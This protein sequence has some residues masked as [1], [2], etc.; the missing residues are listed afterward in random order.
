MNMK[1]LLLGLL[2]LTF[3]FVIVACDDNDDPTDPTEVAPPTQTETDGGTDEVGL[4]SRA[5]ELMAEWGLPAPRFTPD[6]NIPS[7]QQDYDHFV[8]LV[9]YVNYGWWPAHEMGDSFVTQVMRDDMNIHISFISGGMDNL[10]TMIAGG[11]MPDIITMGGY[12]PLVHQAYEFAFPLN[13][14]AELYDPY[15]LA[16]VAHPQIVN[17]HTLADGHFY[18]MPN[19]AMTADAI[20]AGYAWTNAGFLVRQD[21][22]EELGDV[23]M[24][25]PEGFLAALRGARDLVPYADHGVPLVAFA[26]HA[27]DIME[28]EDGAFGSTLQDFLAIPVV[29]A[30]GNWYDRDADPEYLE[31][32][33]V[34]RQAME[35]GLMNNDQFSDDGEVIQDRFSMGTFF[36]YMTHNTFDIGS[37]LPMIVE[38]APEQMMIPISG[39]RNR[40]GAPH[41]LPAGSLQG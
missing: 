10:N 18:G 36:A 1:K 8:E 5:E 2:A 11:D 4:D 37:R 15:F 30:A 31:W 41:T 25:T 29:D 22:Y 32:L 21:I 6:A 24:T 26:G 27:M 13:V 38:R 34:F 35:E 39:P 9:W 19:D 28:G 14:L 12:L 7:W 23:D 20:S 16:N 17:W 3:M 40:A 33:L